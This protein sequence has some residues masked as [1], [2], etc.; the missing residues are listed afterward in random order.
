M[1]ILIPVV[2]VTAIGLLCAVILVVASKVMAVPS[3]EKFTSIRDCLPGANCGACG[4]AGCDGYAKAL[5]DETEK[6]TNLC[7]PGG[8]PAAAHIAS[9]LGVEAQDVVEK[10]AFVACCGNSSCTT[11]KHDYRGIPSCA[12]A[13]LHYSGDSACSHGCLGYGDCAAVCPNHAIVI[14]DGLARVR[15]DLC[16]GCGL[17]AKNCPNHLIKIVPDVIRTIVRCCNVDKGAITRK[18]CKKGCIGCGKC[19]R[20]CPAGA[21]KVINNCAEIDHDICINCGHCVEACITGCIVELDLT[22]ITKRK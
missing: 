5:A 6:V 16:S 14:E 13:N 12:A 10:V 11:L 7:I 22:S 20:E 1:N 2:C 19:A 15:P 8:D 4:Y 21:I 9:V 17:C 18:A 3:D